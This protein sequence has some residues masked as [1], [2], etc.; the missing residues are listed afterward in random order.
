MPIIHN[1]ATEASKYRMLKMTIAGTLNAYKKLLKHYE[2]DLKQYVVDDVPQPLIS[3]QQNLI[4]KL[5][6]KIELLTDLK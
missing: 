6:A 1:I 3:V 5:K 4:I 2:V